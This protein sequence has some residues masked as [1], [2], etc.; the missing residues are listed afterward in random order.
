MRRRGLT[1]MMSPSYVALSLT[2]LIAAAQDDLGIVE[3]A[4]NRDTH[5]VRALLNQRVAVNARSLDGATAVEMIRIVVGRSACV[6]GAAAH[7]DTGR[8][9]LQTRV[10]R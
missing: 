2:L 9:R 6:S 1:A 3:A 5:A 4:R 10:S 7:D 8:R